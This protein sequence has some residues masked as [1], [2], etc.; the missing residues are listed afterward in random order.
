MVGKATLA[1]I[2]LGLGHIGKS[3]PAADCITGYTDCCVQSTGHNC[4]GR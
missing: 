3:H 1:G 2:D 4:K